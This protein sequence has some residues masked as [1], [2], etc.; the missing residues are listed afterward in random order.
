MSSY[1]LITSKLKTNSKTAYIN[2]YFLN[3]YLYFKLIKHK[4]KLDVSLWF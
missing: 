1:N 4:K 2:L 3:M